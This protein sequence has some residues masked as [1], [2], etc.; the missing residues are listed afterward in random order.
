MA[1]AFKQ[2]HDKVKTKKRESKK[3]G[4]GTE[5][6]HGQT[7]TLIYRNSADLSFLICRNE[8][9]LFCEDLV[10]HCELDQWLGTLWRSVAEVGNGR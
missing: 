6:Y 10:V 3:N 2:T 5:F 8:A 7:S 9:K 1:T 4:E